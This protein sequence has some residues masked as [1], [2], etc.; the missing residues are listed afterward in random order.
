MD[1]PNMAVKGG[2]LQKRGSGWVDMDKGLGSGVGGSG[3]HC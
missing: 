3:I 2:I 1:T